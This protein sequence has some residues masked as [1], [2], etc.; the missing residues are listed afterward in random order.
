ML[1][2]APRREGPVNVHWLVPRAIRQR[3]ERTIVRVDREHRADAP[4]IGV[5]YRTQS[6]ITVDDAQGLGVACKGMS[7]DGFRVAWRHLVICGV[8]QR[9][10]GGHVSPDGLMET[11]IT[12]CGVRRIQKKSMCCHFTYVLLRYV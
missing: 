2:C 12:T 4:Q 1:E 10:C 8:L 3:A 11:P 6:A 9:V 5:W 7:R